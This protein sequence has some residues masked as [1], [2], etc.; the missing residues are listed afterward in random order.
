M[1]PE[2]NVLVVES[3]IRGPTLK[4]QIANT[5]IHIS[6]HKSRIVIL[7][8]Q[9]QQLGIIMCGGDAV[10]E[11]ELILCCA[12]CCVNCSVLPSC[13]CI[14]CSGKVSREICHRFG[15]CR[16]RMQIPTIR[17]VSTNRTEETPSLPHSLTHTINSM[18]CIHSI[19]RQVSAALMRSAAA[20]LA[21]PVFFPAA[22]S[23]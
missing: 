18:P 13:G 14:G 16:R 15:S 19:Y 2:R 1:S 17:L 23:D 21:H 20:S 22:A 11:E 3:N 5:N 12:L 6:L 10:N 7:L 8:D 9:K 4:S